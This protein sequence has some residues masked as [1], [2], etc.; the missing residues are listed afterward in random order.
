[1]AIRDRPVRRRSNINLKRRRTLTVN[2]L[3]K[4]RSTNERLPVVL[5]QDLPPM[6]SDAWAD[7]N[8]RPTTRGQCEDGP[9]PCPWVGCRFHLFIEESTTGRPGMVFNWPD[10][11]PWELPE[12]CTLDV[13]DGPRTLEEVGHFLN[14]TRE[15][16]RQVE[17]VAMRKLMFRIQYVFG[18]KGFLE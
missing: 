2:E 16:I 1:M 10:R 5:L 11:E 17:V 14:L 7:T 12:T 13:T 18:L 9:R 3:S 4:I 8:D 15:R 6:D